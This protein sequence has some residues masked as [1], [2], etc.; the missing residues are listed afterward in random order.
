ML[1]ADVAQQ[2]GRRVELGDDEIGRAVAVDLGGDEAARSVSL[3]RV[4]A[5]RMA[6]IFK[7]AVAAIAEDANLRAGFGFDDGG[8]IDPAVVVDVDG[9]EAPA[10]QSA[11][12]RQIDA[13]KAAA[14]VV[15]PSTLRQRVRPGAP[16]WVTAM[17]IQPSLLK[18][19][20]AMPTV[21]GSLRRHRAAA[22]D[23]CLR[24]D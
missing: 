17:S 5:E 4:E 8:E 19:R 14:D 2:D 18:S 10:A 3:T 7:S 20:T 1:R 15:R 6:D 24:A 22:W 16:A 23:I 9:G 12:Q 13:V 21:G 11:R